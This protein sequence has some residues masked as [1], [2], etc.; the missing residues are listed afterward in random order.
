LPVRD[1]LESANYD[2]ETVQVICAAYDRA[3]K[4]LRDKGQPEIVREILAQRIL[5]L[6]ARGERDPAQLCVAALSSLPRL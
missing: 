2:P 4:E 5:D 1:L 6:A 3:K